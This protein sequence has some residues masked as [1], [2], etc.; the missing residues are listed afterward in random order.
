MQLFMPS[1]V[2]L[3]ALGFAGPALANPVLAPNT[4]GCVSEE[5]LSQ[6]QVAAGRKDER[7]FRSLL[8]DGTCAVVAGFE[9][10]VLDQGIMVTEVRVYTPKGATADL[11]VPAEFA[12]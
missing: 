2:I 6:M 8:L 9:Y 11:F 1:I 12:Q 7:L 5:A 4:V 10:S 3:A